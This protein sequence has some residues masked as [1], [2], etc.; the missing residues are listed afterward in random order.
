MINK[1][2]KCL[3]LFLL[4]TLMGCSAEEKIAN[5]VN[6]VQV[7]LGSIIKA[8][9]AIGYDENGRYKLKDDATVVRMFDNN[10]ET[11][12][13]SDSSGCQKVGVSVYLDKPAYFKKATIFHH[14]KVVPLLGSLTVAQSASE[15]SFEVWSRNINLAK[16]SIQLLDF[17]GEY[18]PLVLRGGVFIIFLKECNVTNSKLEISEIK[19]EFSDLPTMK[20]QMTIQEV[21]TNV[22]KLVWS[23]DKKWNFVDDENDPSKKKYLSHLMYYGLMGDSEADRLF[24]AYNPHSTDLSE[25]L[26][27]IESWYID[28]KAAI[29]SKKE[30]QNN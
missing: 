8:N 23:N 30:S 15:D 11:W 1:I 4:T 16:N 29:R 10:N 5:N 22:K 25:D 12:W 13:T 21:I 9:I 17:T 26:S 2:Y 6:P 24:M 18:Y 20:P 27:A 3:L 7:Q 19:L 14:G 28:D